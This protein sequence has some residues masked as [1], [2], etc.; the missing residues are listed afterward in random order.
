MSRSWSFVAAICIV[1]LGAVACDGGETPE[2]TQKHLWAAFGSDN[3]TFFHPMQ[4][5]TIAKA[6]SL[7]MHVDYSRPTGWDAAEQ[8]AMVR[9]QIIPAAP[10]FLLISP[11]SSTELI[12]PLGEAH[13]AGIDII[14]V[15]TFIGNNTYGQGGEADFPLVYIGTDN[16]A[17]GGSGCNALAALIEPTLGEGEVGEILIF[18]TTHDVSSL[19]SRI[20]GCQGALASNDRVDVAAVIYGRDHTPNGELTGADWYL[21]EQIQNNTAIKGIFAGSS[22]SGIDALA[23][24]KDLNAEGEVFNVIFDCRFSHSEEFAIGAMQACVSQRIE[25]M[26]ELAVDFANDYEEGTDPA[27]RKLSTDSVILTA[28]T[29]DNPENQGFLF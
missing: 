1:S 26:G 3:V 15:D 16:Y 9:E 14:T 8:A 21:E 24:V 29:I 6:E 17:A 11:I 20:A 5:A 25:L 4:D 23:A 7:G 2:V 13:D 18:V 28:D 12:A 19:E 27:F 10:D 22:N